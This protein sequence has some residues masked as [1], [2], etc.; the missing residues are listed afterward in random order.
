MATKAAG[1]NGLFRGKALIDIDSGPDGCTEYSSLTWHKNKNNFIDENQVVCWPMVKLGDY[2]F[3]LST[4][5]AGLM[6]KVD[7]ENAG[8]PYESPSNKALNIDGCCL[9]DGTEINLTWEQ[10]QLIAGSYGI[11][12]ALNFMSMGWVA[13]GNYVGCYPANT[14][15]KD[16]FIPVSRMFDWVGNTLIRTFWSKLDKP[17]TR[18]LVD[19]ILDTCNLWLAGLV[20][21][22]R[23][24]GARAEMLAEENPL[25][26]LMAGIL[27]IHIYITPPSPAQEIDFTLEYDPDYVQAALSE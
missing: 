2:R 24:L 10:V 7:T 3:H 13:K 11:V 14:D 4:Q 26:D 15:V 25:L 16:Y 5:M 27:R 1:I 19:S 18:R 12:T 9:A 20:S 21:A 17:M 22:E 23:L 8:C 6:A